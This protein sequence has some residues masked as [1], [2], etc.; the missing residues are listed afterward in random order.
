MYSS[1]SSRRR[2]SRS[3]PA[4]RFERHVAVERVVGRGLVGQHVG[5]DAAPHQFGH[6]LG[7]VADQADR[8]R[9]PLRAS[10]RAPGAAPRR[11]RGTCGR[12]SR[13]CRRRSMRAGSTSTPRKAAPFMV[14]A[15]GCAPPMPP[16]PAVTTSRPGQ[17]CRRSA[18]GAG[19]ER[20]VGALQDALRAD[21][22]PAAGR[23]L[24]VHRQAHRL[25]P[26]ELLPRRPLRHQQAVGDQHA[27]GQL[28]RAEDADRLARLHQQRLVVF[29]LA[30]G[31]D[32]GVEVV[33]GAR[34]LAGAAVDDEAVGVLGHLGVE[35]VHEHAQG[36][37]LDPALA[38][39][40]GAARGTDDAMLGGGKGGGGH[41]GS[42]RTGAG[43][44]TLRRRHYTLSL[45][46][47]E[48]PA[49]LES[50][51]WQ[52]RLGKEESES[53]REEQVR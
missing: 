39:A 17:A 16:R 43:D 31:G 32:D 4:I 29:E 40:L 33:P 26:A 13:L 28:V 42:S 36:R 30:Q 50:A 1:G 25:Q 20:L 9:L 24:A 2:A 8:Q 6:D 27:R 44:R 37:F 34:R 14:A 22:D 3:S 12:G 45:T 38:G 11:G 21:V 46:G 41:G 5:H 18:G 53:V 49:A 47:A 23:H 48:A 35:V 19:G 51:P 10:R 7:G 52:S 15:S